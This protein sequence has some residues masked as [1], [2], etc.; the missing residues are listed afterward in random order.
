[1][2]PQRTVRWNNRWY[3]GALVL[4]LMLFGL[5]GLPRSQPV[6]DRLLAL[7]ELPLVLPE[8]VTTAL[9]Q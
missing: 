9:L 5:A 6:D 3:T 8:G 2:I 4:A 7:Q 1:M